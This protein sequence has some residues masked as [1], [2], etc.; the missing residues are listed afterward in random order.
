MKLSAPSLSAEQA[1]HEFAV[2]AGVLREEFV[3]GIADAD[4]Q[5]VSTFHAD[6]PALIRSAATHV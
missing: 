1:R 2:L 3:F 6:T 4:P 5:L